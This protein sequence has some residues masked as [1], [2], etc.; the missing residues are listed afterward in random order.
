[1][2]IR[3][4]NIFYIFGEIADAYSANGLVQIAVKIEQYI[5]KKYILKYKKSLPD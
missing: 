5:L 4:E 3:Y 1:M 2:R